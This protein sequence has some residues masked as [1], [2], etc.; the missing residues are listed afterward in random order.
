MHKPVSRLEYHLVTLSVPV[1]LTVYG[2][3]FHKQ[4][5][6]TAAVA[7]ASYAVL[8]L[9]LEVMVPFVRWATR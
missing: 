1:L 9:G 8:R 3:L 7:M 6:G 2:Q 5:F 4:F